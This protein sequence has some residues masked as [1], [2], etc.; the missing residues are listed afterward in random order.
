MKM[1]WLFPGQGSQRPGMGTSWYGVPESRGWLEQAASRLE[2]IPLRHLLCDADETALQDTNN[3]QPAMYAIG[4]AVARYLRA[5]GAEPAAVAGHSLGEIT[6]LAACGALD[7]EWGLYFVRER[8]RLMSQAP[9]GGMAAVLGL[10]AEAIEE[11]LPAEVN[12]ANFNGPA[13]T[14]ISGTIAG[15]AA[16]EEA[17]KRAGAKRVIPLR[18]S[19]PFHSPLMRPVADALARVL[20]DAPITAPGCPFYSTVS[21]A[22]ETDPERIRALLAEQVCAPVRWTETASL[23]GPVAALEAGPGGVLQGLCRRIP[24]A[25]DVR[26]ADT[27]EACRSLA[28][29]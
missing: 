4:L 2:N 23:I 18:V 16:A 17:L 15:L 29:P 9:E 13:Q 24:G 8:A 22:R 21:A 10:S 28:T 14:V 12:V 6:A 1:V 7:P 25:P 3:A 11:A 19:G 26:P 5:L 27:P 20:R